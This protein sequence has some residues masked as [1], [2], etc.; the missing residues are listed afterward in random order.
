MS[1]DTNAANIVAQAEQ[2][3]VEIQG[4]LD[5]AA[6]FYRE[7]GLNPDKVLSTLEAQLTAKDKEDLDRIIRQD[8]AEIESAVDDAKARASFAAAPAS[9]GVK[10]PRAMV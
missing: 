1:Q 6:D 8:M 4:Q 2:L 9:G 3:V 10:K 7:Q 5:A